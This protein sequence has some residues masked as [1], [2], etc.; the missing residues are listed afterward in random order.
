MSL[1]VPVQEVARLCRRH[2]VRE[3]ALFGSA[4][5]GELRPDSDVDV[6][7]EFEPEARASLFTL[8]EME[9]ELAAL[10]GRRVEL[11]SKAGLRPL[12]REE[13]LPSRV[14]VYAA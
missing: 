13:I 2:G 6:L 1:E 5:R 3:L 7:V 10:L 4:A 9:D 12:L 14:I 11:V 8:F